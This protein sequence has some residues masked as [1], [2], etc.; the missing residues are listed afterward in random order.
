MWW[1]QIAVI[2][3]QGAGDRP[4]H[5]YCRYLHNPRSST[6]ALSPLKNIFRS[7]SWSGRIDP[8]AIARHG[9]PPGFGSNLEKQLS[10]LGA[11]RIAEM[12]E[13][14]ITM[15]V[16]SASGPGAYLLDGADGI[17]F[18]RHQRR[19]EEGGGGTPRTFR[20]F[21]P[22]ADANAASGCR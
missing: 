17:G 8:D 16:L 7:L 9:Y 1:G 4:H 18:A 6:C 19:I 10:D 2:S 13:A 15:H 20:R 3:L 21:C 22:S 12:D 11:L 5:A 14:G